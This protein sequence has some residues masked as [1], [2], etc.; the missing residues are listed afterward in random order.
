MEGKLY[1]QDPQVSGLLSKALRAGQAAAGTSDTVIGL[2]ASATT[3]GVQLLDSI[4]GRENKP[5]IVLLNGLEQ[6]KKYIDPSNLL[7]V[8]KLADACWP[9]PVTLIV[10]AHAQLP[11]GISSSQGT[12]AMRV[13]HH[14]ELRELS[15]LTGG[16]L[17]T[18]ANLAGQPV[19]A[20]IEKIDQR[21]MD[22]ITY[23]VDDKESRASALPSTIIDCT[24]EIFVVI[25]EGAYP[26]H[27]LQA[28]SGVRIE[29]K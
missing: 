2:I 12:I 4:K 24:Q 29:K 15:A 13:P 21:I 20:T 11:I 26:I 9:G 3:E 27:K 7:Q 14:K 28:I 17:S 19:P 10:K 1:W 25:R 18:S 22:K 8:E 23:L 6:A 5:Y 16:L